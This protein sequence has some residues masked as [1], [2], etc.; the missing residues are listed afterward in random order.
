MERYTIKIGGL[1]EVAIRGVP[2]RLIEE[3][4]GKNF[5]HPYPLILNPQSPIPN[6]QKIKS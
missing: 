4:G 5:S 6:P 2:V 3:V 1:T